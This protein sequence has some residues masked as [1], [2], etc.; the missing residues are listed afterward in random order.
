[1]IFQIPLDRAYTF[2]WRPHYLPDPNAAVPNLVIKA[3]GQTVT[4]ALSKDGNASITGIP[5][6]YRLSAPASNANTLQGLVGAPGGGWYLYLKGHGQFPVEVSHFDD[7]AKEYILSE[8]LPHGL[9]SD[10]TGSLNH[11]TWTA[12]VPANSFASVDRSGLYEIEWTTDF[13]TS[14]NN[15]D[16]EAFTERGRVRVVRYPFETGLTARNLK[17]LVP[18]LEQSRPGNRDGWQELIDTIDIIGS[19]ESRLPPANYADQT[20]PEQWRRAHA[21]LVAAHIAEVGYA[22]N[23]DAERMRELAEEEL[24]R[25]ARRVHWLDAD[26]DDVVDA[27]EKNFSYGKNT[28]LVV[29]SAADTLKTYTDGLRWRPT[30]TDKDDR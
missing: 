3:S 13:D 10:A 24:D 11:N 18:Q 25:Q 29:S 30:L 8:P 4:I 16:G 1:M 26:D 7:S 5:D 2:R 14:G 27:D 28:K 23:V 22:A 6:R 9:P 17:T 21:L 20:L 19:V 12:V 15:I